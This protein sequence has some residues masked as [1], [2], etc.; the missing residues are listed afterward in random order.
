MNDLKQQTDLR[1]F[2]RFEAHRYQYI[3]L[4]IFLFVFVNNS[5]QATS[6]WL[7]LT[8]ETDFPDVRMWE[9]FVWE[10]SSAFAFFIL[11]PFLFFWFSYCPIR[12]EKL[13]QQLV[14]HLVATI[15]F[16]ISHVFLMVIMREGAYLLAGGD[17]QFGHI[18]REFFYE[19]RKDA[20]SYCFWLAVFHLYQF[21]Y[22]RLK[23][24]AQ[25]IST[26]SQTKAASDPKGDIEHLLVKKIDK[27]FLVLVKEI[28]W[29]ESA[30]NYVNLHSQGRIYPLRTTMAKLVKQLQHHGFSRSHRSFAVN[31]HFIDLIKSEN[32][33]DATIRMK[34]GT[35]V[36]LSRRYKDDFKRSIDGLIGTDTEC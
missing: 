6:A 36:P 32:G 15:I 27:E 3:A 20:W 1:R 8:R 7:E 19:Y 4:W 5:I 13:G 21:I 33:G 2:E 24:E 25:I 18:G 9:P 10:Y 16:S 11:T 31:K 12:A 28:E 14:Y 23:G 34:N 35:Y 26:Q 29:L 17:Y 30:G 22:S